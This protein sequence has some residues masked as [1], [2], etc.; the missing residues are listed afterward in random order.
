FRNLP[1]FSIDEVTVTGATTNG[2]AI[3]KAVEQVAGDMTTLHLNDDELRNVVTHFPTVASVGAT[4]SF[5]HTLHVTVTERLPVAFIKVGDRRTAVSADGYL[6]L[7]ASFNP[8]QLPRIEGAVGNGAR[9][10]GDAAAQAAILGAIPAPLRD[11]I[12]S[13]TWSDSDGGVVVSLDGGP[14]LRF[15]D[16]SRAQ[17]KW[18]AA[19][20]V[21]SSPEHGSPAY[22]DVSVPERPVTGG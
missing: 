5:P 10:D 20:A 8:K 6:L 11:Q 18:T 15:G 1:L 19:V 9:L 21:L 17:D 7:G 13:S 3:K 16:G 4:T 12:A 2:P 14:D 22:L